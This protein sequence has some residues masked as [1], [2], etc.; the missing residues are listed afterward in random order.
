MEF[1]VDMVTTVPE[2]TDG[3]TVAE[4]KAREAVRA[5]EL[6]RQGHLLRLW[7]PPVKPGEWRIFGLF[8]AESEQLMNEILADLPLYPWMA[9]EVT[10][11]AQHPNDPAGGKA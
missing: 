3:A 11:L 6:A 1:L 8:S 10:P 2:G 4:T 7:T 9:I 5:A